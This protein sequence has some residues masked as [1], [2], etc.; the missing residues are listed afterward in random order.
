MANW[1]SSADELR[2]TLSVAERQKFLA[3]IKANLPDKAG[4]FA[5]HHSL[6][7]DAVWNNIIGPINRLALGLTT[8]RNP[9]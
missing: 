1:F 3:D 9:P 7:V 6:P 5:V 2:A 4:T 8:C